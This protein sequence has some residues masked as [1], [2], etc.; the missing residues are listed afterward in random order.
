MKQA[1][2]GKA[3]QQTAAKQKQIEVDTALETA[4]QTGDVEGA[5]KALAAGAHRIAHD[6][7]QIHP[8]HLAVNFGHP[9]VVRVLLQAGVDV[10]LRSNKEETTALHEAASQNRLS[11]AAVLIEHGSDVNARDA[12]GQTPLFL[13]AKNNHAEM[14]GFLHKA[15]AKLEIIDHK[16]S[17]GIHA[18]MVMGSAAT[19]QA[20]TEAG[21][22]LEVKCHHGRT[23]L[24]WALGVNRPLMALHLIAFGANPNDMDQTA[25]PEHH[26]LP[27]L[28]AAA[29]AGMTQRALALIQTGA[30]LKAKHR[31]RTPLV[32][33]Q[34]AKHAET[35]AAIQAALARHAMDRALNRA[36]KATQTSKKTPGTP[37]PI[38]QTS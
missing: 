16:G 2:S 1:N 14:I 12:L 8:I 38:G 27:A 6:I 30:S 18:A 31:G 29:R 23:P 28:H 33:A 9:E 32:E 17:L 34:R 36:F 10:A 35:V 22:D 11:C 20:W 26:G 37:R 4:C 3:N 7:N 15:G 19:V 13:A 24:N 5:R 25:Y 21:G